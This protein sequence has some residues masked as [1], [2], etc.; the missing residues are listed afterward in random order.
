M[1]KQQDEVRFTVIPPVKP[2]VVYFNKLNKRNK[3]QK[4]GKIE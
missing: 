2:V 1:K 3:I 4:G